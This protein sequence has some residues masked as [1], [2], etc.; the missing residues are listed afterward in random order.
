VFV[1]Y[2]LDSYY[3]WSPGWSIPSPERYVIGGAV[4][5]CAVLLLGLWPVLLFR[6]SG[7]SANP[8]RPTPNIEERGPFAFTRNPM[9]LQMVLVCLGVG[10]ASMNPWTITLTPL[11]AWGLWR[12]AIRPEEDYLEKKFGKEYL[13]YKSRVRRWL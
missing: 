4:I 9:Y 2:F 10:I 1:G 6:K 12:A 13:E 5:V 7:Q 11:V 3:P 8:W